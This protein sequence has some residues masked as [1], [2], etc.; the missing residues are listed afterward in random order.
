VLR[1]VTNSRHQSLA[2]FLAIA[3]QDELSMTA[4]RAWRIY[5]PVELPR[6]MWLV[7]ISSRSVYSRWRRIAANFQIAAIDVKQGRSGPLVL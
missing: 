1:W 5:A 4:P 2:Q 6:R 7:A 3:R